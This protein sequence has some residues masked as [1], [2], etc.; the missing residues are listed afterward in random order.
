MCLLESEIVCV[1]HLGVHEKLVKLMTHGRA[2]CLLAPEQYFNFA[3]RLHLQPLFMEPLTVYHRLEEYSQE[4]QRK[5]LLSLLFDLLDDFEFKCFFNNVA[6]EWSMGTF[7][8]SGC[9]LSFLVS[10]AW[11][12]IT[13]SKQYVD[14]LCISLFDFSGSSLSEK[15]KDLLSQFIGQL[16]TVS[17]RYKQ[18]SADNHVLAISSSLDQRLRT[19]DTLFSYYKTLSH[20]LQKKLLPESHSIDVWSER[21]GEHKLIPYPVSVIRD[22][23][24]QRRKDL[25]NLSSAC[26]LSSSSC[27]ALYMVDNLVSYLAPQGGPAAPWGN[28]P[29][30][31]PSI[32]TLLRITLLEDVPLHVKDMLLYYVLLDVQHFMPSATNKE[33]E[34]ML[35]RLTVYVLLRQGYRNMVRGLWCLDH[36]RWTEGYSLLKKVPRKDLPTWLHYS[37]VM[38]L[39]L[40]RENQLAYQYALD[41]K[42]ECNTEDQVRV[43]LTTMLNVGRLQQGLEFLKSTEFE[44][45][46]LGY[47]L[48]SARDMQQLSEVCELRGLSPYEQSELKKYLESQRT[49]YTDFLWV[50]FLYMKRRYCEAYEYKQLVQRRHASNILSVQADG[51]ET[52]AM[53]KFIWVTDRKVDYMYNKLV[54]NLNKEEYMRSKRDVNSVL[55]FSTVSTPLNVLTPQNR[56][57]T[58][59]SDT[60]MLTN[61]TKR[62][63]YEFEFDFAPTPRPKVNDTL[64]S[65]PNLPLVKADPNISALLSTPYVHKKEDRAPPA[66]LMESVAPGSTQKPNKSL[67]KTP[68][69][70]SSSVKKALNFSSEGEATLSYSMDENEDDAMECEDDASSLISEDLAY[71]DV[72]SRAPIRSELSIITEVSS[73]SS[74]QSADDSGDELPLEASHTV[75]IEQETTAAASSEASYLHHVSSTSTVSTSFTSITSST[76][77]STTLGDVSKLSSTSNMTLGDVSKLSSTSN[78][79]LGD[80][81]K[82]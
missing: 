69:G 79:S 27:R 37:V 63:R 48:D 13:R 11:E 55:D 65:P 31:P 51:S 82:L 73:E 50:D 19:L 14:K 46:L 39:L 33:E 54:P 61:T 52:E 58:A 40:K 24:D 77:R 44:P 7:D 23:A 10:W 21:D 41:F 70:S 66:E 28:T 16:D 5:F 30:P 45:R 64:G 56:K 76:R 59:D 42:P 34:S 38:L 35:E 49:R 57:R 62:G 1:S 72:V 22:Y 78:M 81:S 8:T 2:S 26:R 68:G 12:H 36:N 3:V 60:T 47:F 75:E 29:Y 53:E 15:D 71:N 25:S 32:Q 17:H 4:D 80:V 6:K 9:S 20:L 18:F 43:K 74:Y 67:L